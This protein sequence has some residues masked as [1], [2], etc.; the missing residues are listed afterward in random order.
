MRSIVR[1][2]FWSLIV[3][4]CA[5]S[6]R[7]HSGHT[8]WG[9]W[10]LDWEVKDSAG[11]ALRN[12]YFNNELAIYKA[13]L[14]VIRV[15]YNN[16]ACGPYADRISW[17]NLVNISNC[18][19]KKVCQ[20]SFSSGGRN[21]LEIGVYARIGSYHIY[22]AWYLSHDGWIRA[23]V[24]S[25]G[26][27]CNTDHEHHPYWRMDLDVNGAPND[28]IF[29]FD[30]NRPNEGWGSG[31]HKHTNEFNETKNPPTDRKWFV[32]D[33]PGGH[34]VWAIPAGDD[35]TADSFS[36]KDAAGRRYKYAEDVGWAF[37]ASGHLGYNEAEDI[38]EKDVI[39]WYVCHLHHSASEGGGQWH[40]CGPWFFLAR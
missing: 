4:G 12:V 24:W 19:N 36:N 13:S 26:L 20:A 29:V 11:I 28:Q 8:V 27:Q 37:G 39:F 22:Q 21:W 7:A 31:W 32:R 1:F 16:N 18:G 38:Q 14:P 17:S 6:A 10:T 3:I 30:N 35:G 23:K 25:K 5:T 40:A 15:R 2:V 9:G 34:G 33:H